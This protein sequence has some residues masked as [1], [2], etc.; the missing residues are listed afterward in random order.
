MRRTAT[1]L[2]LFFWAC[3][4]TQQPGNPVT[5]QP[6][7][8]TNPFLSASS[9][10]FQAPPFDRIKDTDYQPAIE[11]GMK[12]QLAEIDTIANNPAPPTFANTIEA[13]ERSGALLTRVSKVFFNLT[14]SNTNDT[15]QKIEADEAPKLASHQDSIYLNP[16]LFARVKSLYDSRD[17]LGLDAQGKYLVE[18]Y[19]KNFVR[20]GALLSEADKT[21]LRA[22]NQE[23]STLTT[24]FREKVLADTKDSAIVVDNKADLAGLSDEDI[25]SAAESAKERGLTGKWV[26]PLQNTTQQPPL[27][28]LQNRSLRQR[29]LAASEARGNHGGA[30]D[31][32]STVTRLA[33]LRADKAKLLGFPTYATYVLDDQMAKTPENAIKLM[34]DLVP[35]STQHA[36]EEAAKMQK[37]S[38]DPLAAADWQFYAEQV[39]KAEY[40]LDENQVRPYFEI[41]RVLHDGVFYA[42]NQLYGLTFKERKD[43]PV[44]QP[45]VRV[46][47]VFDADGKSMALFYADYYARGNK[48][49]G[50]WMDSFVDQSGLLGTRPVVLNVCNFTKPAPGQPALLSFTDVTTM[51]HEFGHALHGMFSNVNYPTLAGTN[52]PRDFVEFPSQFNEHWAL[53]P[54]VFANY[55]K[56]Y[57]TGAPMPQTL[58]DKIKKSRTFNQGYALTEYLESALLDMAWHTTQP[59]TPQQDVNTFEPSALERFQI[60]MPLIPPRYHTTYFSHV[61]GGGYAA[62]YYAYLWSELIDDDAFYWFRENGGMTRANGQRFRD[63]I[64]SRGGSQDLATLYRTFR[65]RDPIADPLLIERGLKSPTQPTEQK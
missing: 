23:E 65:G 61:W 63:M 62:G 9:L 27:T 56:H 53:E 49:G 11:Q 29:L 58:V 28:Y 33:Q 32:K 60:A 6:Q 35:A 19:Y 40:D 50:A 25:A 7:T 45:D 57:Q 39:R 47:E 21:A 13:M 41:N 59:G 2:Y 22:L 55:A 15:M 8:A 17:S 24:K 46:F 5:A 10:Q 36:R 48:S 14:Q 18:R 44:Y 1:I 37:L 26:L 30:N 4:T 31:T 34:T 42:A 52:V 20:A 43:I 3:A 64:L 38:P 12:Q 54:K 51:F 16:K